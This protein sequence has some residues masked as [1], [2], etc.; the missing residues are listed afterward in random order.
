MGTSD[1]W[2]IIINIL[3]NVLMEYIEEKDEYSCP[4]YCGVRHN[5]IGVEDEF[6][7]GVLGTI[8]SIYIACDDIDEDASGY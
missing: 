1:K 5:H 6:Y 4:S 2:L 7:Y 3:I 8:D